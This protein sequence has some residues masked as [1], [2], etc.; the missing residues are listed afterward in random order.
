MTSAACAHLFGEHSPVEN[1]KIPRYFS[2][3]AG[4]SVHREWSTALIPR[5]KPTRR[6]QPHAGT[7]HTPGAGVSGTLGH[8]KF[9]QTH[10]SVLVLV[11]AGQELSILTLS[12]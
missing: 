1:R 11:G 3:P 9:R 10:S 7:P 12:S 6:S 8:S 4:C 5:V 2:T